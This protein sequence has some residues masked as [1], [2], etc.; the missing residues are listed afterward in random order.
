MLA[1]AN[2]LKLAVVSDNRTLMSVACL[3][4]LCIVLVN[5]LSVLHPMLLFL[6]YFQKLLCES[7]Q[8][9]FTT[10]LQALAR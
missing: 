6:L 10:E 5:T 1:I 9:T 2:V 3:T 4:A 7:N 8:G